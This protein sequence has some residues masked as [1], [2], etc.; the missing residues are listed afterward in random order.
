MNQKQQTAPDA[1][2]APRDGDAVT[3]FV[4][5]C[6]EDPA[7]RA[8]AVSDPA[9]T[10]AERGIAM[11]EGVDVRTVVNSDDTFHV[12]LPPDPNALLEDEALAGTVGG[13]TFGTL[14]CV[15]TFPSCIG[16]GGTASTSEIQR[17]CH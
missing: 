6:M 13:S 17:A 5:D 16:T 2:M 10:L 8:R 1:T 3:A 4:V 7:F 9:G 14:S 12:V 15:S 11:P